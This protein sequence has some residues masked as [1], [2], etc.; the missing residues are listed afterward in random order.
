MPYMSVQRVIALGVETTYGV[1]PTDPTVWLQVDPNPGDEPQMTYLENKAL[2]G[3]PAIVYD[4]VAGV[5]HQKISLKGNYFTDTGPYLTW[6]MLGVDTVSGTAAPYTHTIQLINDPSVGS[7]PSSV[8]IWDIDNVA[9]TDNAGTSG[10]CKLIN[11]CVL[12]SLSLSMSATGALSYTADF[13][14]KQIVE[15][16]IPSTFAF[17][18]TVFL[19]AYTFALSI[20]GTSYP[21]MEEATIDIKRG[22]KPIPTLNGSRYPYTV[23][24]NGIDVTGKFTIIAEPNDPNFWGA[25]KTENNNEL[26]FAGTDPITSTPYTWTLGGVQLKSPKIESSKEW[27]ELTVDYQANAIPSLAISGYSPIEFVFES[28]SATPL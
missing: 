10:A 22:A 3:S 5:E 20:N 21:I 14:G 28:T 26:V 4:V 6:L 1:S 19:P 8:S 15:A 23:W 18:D 13:V 24:D 27:E 2:Y 9:A 17:T 7:Q 16:A 12:D 11:G 25:L